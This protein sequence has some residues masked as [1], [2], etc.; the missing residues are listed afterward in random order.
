M[1][2]Q[3]GTQFLP[4]RFIGEIAY[5]RI[6]EYTKLQSFFLYVLSPVV[7]PEEMELKEDIEQTELLREPMEEGEEGGVDCK[8]KWKGQGCGWVVKE[9]IVNDIEYVSWY[10]NGDEK[11]EPYSLRK[12]CR[13]ITK[14]LYYY[15][16][17]EQE[18][19]FPKNKAGYTGQDGAPGV[20]IS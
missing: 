20:I 1:L 5:K 10:L 16:K 3:S 14:G 6:N 13:G 18:M 19:L 9:M 4:A 15:S 7:L 8:G 2:T 11:E 12:R 17:G